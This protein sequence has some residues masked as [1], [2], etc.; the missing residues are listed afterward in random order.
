M[1]RKERDE[2]NQV[3]REFIMERDITMRALARAIDYAPT[4]FWQFLQGR[5]KGGRDLPEEKLVALEAHLEEKY[6]WDSVK[7]EYRPKT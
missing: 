3:V 6:G 2:V 1:T 7:H 4:N 5:E